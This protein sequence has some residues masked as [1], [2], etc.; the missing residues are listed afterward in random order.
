MMADATG[1][2][3]PEE[4]DFDDGGSD[5]AEPKD[6]MTLLSDQ[7]KM[8]STGDRAGLR[9][10]FLTER[11]DADGVVIGL[12]HR[13]GKDIPVR[14]EAFAPWRLLAHVAA[15]LSGTACLSSH[16]GRRGVGAALHAAGYS[17]TALLRL[18]AARGPMLH[19]Q[20]VRAARRLA[21]KG[22]GPV[23]LWTV[24]DLAGRNATKVE[25]GRLRIAHDFYAAKARS[26]EDSK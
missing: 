15:L 7:I 23:N 21:Q 24:F 16:A 3:E 19:D 1:S 10:I 14:A 5:D 12:L 20:I 25:E 6:V 18:T 4:V 11:H 13:L 8:L 2:D 17:E 26:A 22:E 9:R